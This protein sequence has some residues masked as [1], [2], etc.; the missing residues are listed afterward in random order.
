VLIWGGLVGLFLVHNVTLG[1][2]SACQIWGFRIYESDDISR[3][4]VV[5]GI[6]AL[7]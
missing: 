1:V 4:N 6:L 3:D 7:G 5:F 2:N